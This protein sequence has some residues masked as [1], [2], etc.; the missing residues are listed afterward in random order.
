MADKKNRC[1][2]SV[3]SYKYLPMAFVLADSFIAK[4][5][6][7]DVFL[8]AIDL[9]GRQIKSVTWP[10]PP[11]V[12]LLGLDD[13]ENPLLQKT[14]QYFDVF[15]LCCAAKSFLLEQ[16]L[17]KAGYEKAILLDPDIVCYA[18][19]DQVWSAL[20]YTD[21]AVTPHT[22]SPMPG[23][24]LLPDDR[25]FVNAG[26]INGGFWAAKRSNKS[27]ECLDWMIGK[28]SDFGF[29]LPQINLYADQ[30]WMSCLPWFFPDSALVMR[31][32]GMNVAY[33]N[34]HERT[35]SLEDGGIFSNRER[36]IFFHFS[37]Y[38]NKQPGQLTKHTSRKFSKNNEMILQKIIAE[39]NKQLVATTR[40]LPRLE[41]DFPCGDL[42]IH[43]RLKKY[44]AVR[45]EKLKFSFN[46][47][48]LSIISKTRA[49]LHTVNERIGKDK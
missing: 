26:F 34:L 17:F 38:D 8:L 47:R 41:P 35:L 10:V 15:E 31:N 44:E 4:N 11:F 24:G 29:F 20:E 19:F 48:G 42:E 1:L 6:D 32:P 37:G 12:K 7:C 21:L 45:G 22:S 33:W 30:T 39:Y 23:D 13:I 27:K 25:E 28:V 46:R 5:P 18:P 16:T 14:R 40:K 9:S 49:L 43:E 36:L 2:L 3:A